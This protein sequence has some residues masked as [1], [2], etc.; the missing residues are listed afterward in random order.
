MTFE[1]LWR[2]VV[3]FVAL[4]LVGSA[5]CLPLYKW[6]F[7]KFFASQLWTKVV[8]WIPIFSVFVAVLSSG[9]VIAVLVTAALLLQAFREF[10][11]A[12][13]LRSRVATLYLSFFVIALMHLGGFFYSISSDLATQA[14]IV[15][16]FAS[17][18]SDVCAFFAGR[19]LGRTALPTWIN[20]KKSWEGVVG[21]LVGALIGYGLVWNYLDIKGY[22]AIALGIGIASALGDLANSTAKRSLRI[23]DWGQTIPG[24]GGVLDRFSSLSV[25]IAWTFWMIR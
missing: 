20:S 21:Q 13:A 16:C 8:W 19:Y 6:D 4:F 17:V 22:W 11:E 12:K 14:L 2:L 23:K 15:V 3:L 5:L 18:M 10:Y 24:H 25:A 7:K 1:I 9:S